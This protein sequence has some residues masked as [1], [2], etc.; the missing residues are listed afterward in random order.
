M[1]ELPEVE[2]LKNELQKAVINKKI[3]ATDI[4]APRVIRQPS[5][6]AFR[7]QLAGATI[8]RVLRRAKLLILEL[9]NGKSL[10]VHLKM[11]GQLI[12][13]GGNKAA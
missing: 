12:Y 3:V 4:Y 7:S 1:P 2:S 10:T 5:A 9:S 6:G 8:T 11:T 13:P